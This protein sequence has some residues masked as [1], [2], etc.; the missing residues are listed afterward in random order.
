[1]RSAFILVSLLA[2][3]PALAQATA[4]PAAQTPEVAA[5]LA[6]LEKVCLPLASGSDLKT[7]ARSAGL[8]Q[9]DG[10]W[11]LP[12]S[13][14][15]EVDIAP[16]DTANPHVCIATLRFRGDQAAA[17]RTAIGAW[18]A[19]QSPP[20]TPDQVAAAEKG[21]QELRTI[22]SWEA[23]TP[24]AADAVLFTKEK[25]LDG[26]PIDGALNEAQLIVSVTPTKPA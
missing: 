23:S 2:A 5:A 18:A 22:S 20:L 26:K 15:E 3:G 13:G 11:V 19:R 6:A 1:M 14:P 8:R 25:T 16:P 7:V 21:P 9:Q 12:I 17:M 4:K 10:G 24:K